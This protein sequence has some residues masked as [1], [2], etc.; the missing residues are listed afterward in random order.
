MATYD[1]DMLNSSD[2]P[3]GDG[4]PSAGKSRGCFFYG[5]VFSLVGL[6][7]LTLSMAVG[8]FLLYR[9]TM[10][11]FEMYTSS[12]PAEI[13]KAHITEKQQRDALERF[14]AFRE[15]VEA[16]RPTD[17]LVLDGDDLNALIQESPKFKD[18]VYVEIDDDKI[19]A[20]VSLPLDELFETSLTRGRY[21]NGEADIKAEIDDG[22][23]TVKIE[24]VSVDGKPLP[25]AFREMLDRPNIVLEFDKDLKDHPER[26]A[27]LRGI[28]ELEIDDGKVTLTP[29]DFK[30]HQDKD[31]KDDH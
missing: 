31:H 24:S 1:P 5:C 19:K 21:L 18:H 4:G 22:E 3:P 13:P 15:A 6:A 9:S 23:L 30:T 29:R 25:E 12:E 27:F 17:P 16:E 10:Q 20:K 26:H 7:L 8:A 14:Q 11:Y 2:F 28:K